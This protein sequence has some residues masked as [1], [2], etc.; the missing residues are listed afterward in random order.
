MR[1]PTLLAP[2]RRSLATLAVALCVLVVPIAAASA[3]D[4]LSGSSPEDQQTVQAM[5]GAVKLTFTSP[6]IALG[7]EVSVKDA[8][9]RDWATGKVRIVDNVVTQPL[10]S[11][12]PGGAYTVVWRV[13]SADSHPVEGTFEFKTTSGSPSAAPSPAAAA[14]SQPA[15]ATPATTSNR[16]AEPAAQQAPNAFPTGIVMAAIAAFVVVAILVA[17]SARRR[18]RR[19]NG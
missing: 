16:P 17:V 14:T 5:P 15:E 19:N 13:V 1:R 3:H 9:G 10:D 2:T 4:S 7:S 18:T 12:A 6:P 8:D 11:A